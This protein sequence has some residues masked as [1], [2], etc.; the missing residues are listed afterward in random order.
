MAPLLRLLLAV[1][2]L[3]NAG[4][5]WAYLTGHREVEPAHADVE[6]LQTQV[7]ELN[8]ELRQAR[9][10][11]AQFRA[12]EATADAAAEPTAPVGQ[13]APPEVLAELHRIEDSVTAIRGL[14]PKS[15]VPIVFL[16]K[17]QLH[18]YFQES[19]DHEYTPEE[20]VQDQKLLSYIG[21]IP[22]SFDLPS[23]IVDLLGE[24]VVGFYDDDQKRMALIGEA[25]DLS[26]DERITF[27]HEYNHTLQDQHFDLQ[28]LNPPNAE[29]D[30]QSLAIQALVEG[31][32]VLTMGLWANQNLTRSEMEEASRGGGEDQNLRQAPLVLRNELLFPYTDGARFVRVL[33]DQG[34]FAA[35]D[36][37]FREPPRST[38]Q[39]LHPEKFNQR[40]EPI[41]VEIAATDQILGPDWTDVI[42]NTLGE[43]DL[44]ILIEQ[45]TDRNTGNRAAA[46]WGGDRYRLVE[47]SDGQ[48][49]LILQTAWDTE[50]DANEF[51]T[52]LT[53]ALRKRFGVSNTDT[54]G[55]RVLIRNSEQPSLIV[56]R[57]GDVLLVMGP[58]EAML[59]QAANALGF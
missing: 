48:L 10:G 12:E 52:A 14:T 27:A 13:P 39:I 51:S 45:F 6:R 23:F 19:F 30:D 41:P 5:G 1:S 59:T 29:N 4:L 17:D 38:E 40:N 7:A 22:A 57:G 56:K 46:G 21:L 42:S 54:S 31:D 24:Q 26:P 58:D 37:A 50:N 16:D 32:A 49:G 20:R 53:Q 36:Q 15:D 2:L 44:R 28:K 47:R 9:S 35:V 25:S 55:S 34:G 18:Q 43:L 11:S 8:A 33:Y 3:T